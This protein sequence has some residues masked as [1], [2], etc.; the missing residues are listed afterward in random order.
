[1]SQDLRHNSFHCSEWLVCSTDCQ[2]PGLLCDWPPALKISLVKVTSWHSLT[3]LSPSNNI[4]QHANVI[5]VVMPGVTR[6]SI[7]NKNILLNRYINIA[8]QIEPYQNMVT[9]SQSVPHP[10]SVSTDQPSG[11]FPDPHP[12]RLHNKNTWRIT[13]P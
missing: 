2:R 10:P 4:T 12:S 3:S 7:Q 5:S 8:L 9:S 13:A 1:M 11:P 6:N